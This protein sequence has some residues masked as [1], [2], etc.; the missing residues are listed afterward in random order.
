MSL[1]TAAPDKSAA[2]WTV[3][4]YEVQMYFGTSHVR[5]NLQCVESDNT[6]VLKNAL[7]ESSLIHARILADILTSKG[8]MPD[9]I[10]LKDLI[11]ERSILIEEISAL[12]TAYGKSNEENSICWTINKR[13]AHPT[14]HRSDSYDYSKEFN[15]LDFHI[16]PLIIRI[17]S[18]A[19]RPLPIPDDWI[20]RA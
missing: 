20:R 8:K 9:D 19:K 14:S 6:R 2:A 12:E 13:F 17:Y 18:L 1:E 4:D 3:M 7:V 5:N 16:K 15:E 10:N 11:S